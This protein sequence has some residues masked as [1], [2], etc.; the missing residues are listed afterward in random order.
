M[1]LSRHL[2]IAALGLAGTCLLAGCA[3]TDAA[4]VPDKAASASSAFASVTHPATAIPTKNSAVPTTSVPQADPA[5]TPTAD[6]TTR[7]K[8]PPFV[9]T[10]TNTVPGLTAAI[11]KAN[12]PG[13]A[14]CDGH[15]ASILVARGNLRTTGVTQFLVDTTCTGATASTPDEVALYASTDAQLTR[16]G[17]IYTATA[18]RP[19]LTAQPYLTGTHTVVLTYDEGARFSLATIT[20]TSID[21]GELLKA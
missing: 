16:N 9:N 6:K 19:T 3:T 7:P 20:P 12:H 4:G 5:S 8:A 18:N 17:V 10:S 13:L 21:Q 11:S 1:F 14:V 2:A 15:Y